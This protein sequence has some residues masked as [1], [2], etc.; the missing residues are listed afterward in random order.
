MF[1]SMAILPFYWHVCYNSR[2]LI[3]Y[4]HTEGL[5]FRT[6]TNAYKLQEEFREIIYTNRLVFV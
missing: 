6:D 2:G 1:S 3:H 5:V 4:K